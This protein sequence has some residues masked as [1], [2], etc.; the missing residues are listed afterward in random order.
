MA[1][2]RSF[3]SDIRLSA[4]NYFNKDRDD[5]QI[6]FV[7]EGESATSL[8]S[9]LKAIDFSKP[10]EALKIIDQVLDR[11][12]SESEMHTLTTQEVDLA[13]E[14][15]AELAKKVARLSKKED[16]EAESAEDE[17]SLPDKIKAF[18]GG[19]NDRIALARKERKQADRAEKIG[20]KTKQVD[21]QLDEAVDQLIINEVSEAEP[22]FDN[23]F[24]LQDKL[25]ALIEAGEEVISDAS[26]LQGAAVMDAT[27]NVDFGNQAVN[28]AMEMSQNLQVDVANSSLESSLNRFANLLSRYK[29]WVSDLDWSPNFLL[30][31]NNM[32]DVS[33]HIIGN[34]ALTTMSHMMDLV[35][36]LS[37]MS[38]ASD[39]ENSV[40]E[41]VD[42]LNEELET[43]EKA[44]TRVIETIREDLKL[45]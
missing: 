16:K 24:K 31:F 32:T 30:Q 33:W 27:M 39:I 29:D 43:T 14:Q 34:D 45:G 21:S 2:T 22:E 23:L 12:R 5:Q 35:G 7:P 11:I 10:I 17:L 13:M 15:V 1:E 38:E 20:K 4:K 28:A 3:V 8:A 18:F 40:Q 9:E 19:S 36:G 41:I 44:I 37:A 25:V 42:S 6:K 26:S